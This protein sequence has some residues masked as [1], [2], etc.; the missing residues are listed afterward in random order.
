MICLCFYWIKKRH[1]IHEQ[2]NRIVRQ[3]KKASMSLIAM[4]EKMLQVI[5]IELVLIKSETAVTALFY[6]T[7]QK[8]SKHNNLTVEALNSGGNGCIITLI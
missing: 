1:I 3:V 5:D 6:S 2:A 7:H 4:K 8:P